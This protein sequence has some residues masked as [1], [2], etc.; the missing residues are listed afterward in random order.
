MVCALLNGWIKQIYI[1]R[2]KCLAMELKNT[3]GIYEYGISCAKSQRI[4]LVDSSTSDGVHFL[5]IVQII[6]IEY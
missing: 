5:L 6:M 3:K 1:F 4:Y 2:N